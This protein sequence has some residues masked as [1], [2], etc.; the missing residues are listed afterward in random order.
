MLLFLFLVDALCIFGEMIKQNGKKKNLRAK[1]HLYLSMMR[2]FAMR[3]DLDM[4][5]RLHIHMWSDSVGSISPSVQIEADEL[6]MEAAINDDQVAPLLNSIPK[7]RFFISRFL[8]VE[9][10]SYLHKLLFIFK[11]QA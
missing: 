3:G 5:K 8:V 11:W 4:V 1:P 9:D 7:L 10:V 6:L 2:A